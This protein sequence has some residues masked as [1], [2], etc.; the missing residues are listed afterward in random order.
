MTLQ[1]DR[2]GQADHH[3]QADQAG[4]AGQAG[5]AEQTGQ[6]EQREQQGQGEPVTQR[7]PADGVD[8]IAALVRDADPGAGWA[9]GGADGPDAVVE[10]GERDAVTYVGGLAGVLVVWPVIGML[11]DAG[12]LALH[13][14]LT[15]YGAGDGLPAGATAH[16]LLTHGSGV[17][18]ALTGLAERLCGSPLAGFAA[19]RI[20][21]PLGMTRTGF[22]ADGTLRAPAADLG[23]FLSHLL[24]PAGGPVSRAWT[25]QSLRIRTGELLPA[26]GLLWHPGAHGSWSHGDGPAL[27]I[28]P[29]G[30]RW[31]A[32]LPTTPSPPLRTAFREAVFA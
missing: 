28:S 20:W 1:S 13:T 6:A 9:V 4:Q 15:A 5:Q 32:L 24:A 19:D 31:A 14:P 7:D 2:A 3:G 17:S 8:R 22:A 25:E 12:E 29:R 10:A 23:R 21:G 30:Q 27:W 18:P 16:Q 26:R 11:V